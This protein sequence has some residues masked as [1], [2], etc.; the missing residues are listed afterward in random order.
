[1]PSDEFNQLSGEKRDN[2]QK[3]ELERIFA[4]REPSVFVIFCC[5]IFFIK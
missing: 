2:S 1:M 5:K 4:Q 3:L